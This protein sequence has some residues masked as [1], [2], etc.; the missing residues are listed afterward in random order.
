METLRALAP[1][2][3]AALGAV[4]GSCIAT[5]LFM[6]LSGVP[7]VAAVVRAGT[8]GSKPLLPFLLM[9]V[10][11]AVGWAFSRLTG[12]DLSVKFRSLSLAMVAVYLPIMVAYAPDRRAAFN[13]LL[14]T[15]V[16]LAAYY[17]GVV[18][19]VPPKGWPDVLGATTT[20]TAVAFAASP[21]A[22]IGRVLKTRDASAIPFGMVSRGGWGG[23]R[24]A[25]VDTAA[26]SCYFTGA[27]LQQLRPLACPRNWPCRSHHPARRRC[28]CSRC[29][30]RRG[31]A[32]ARCWAM[33]GW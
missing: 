10:D 7:D 22:G 21:L 32:T 23:G 20:M 19:L 5:T 33:R 12:D 4:R 18:S 26:D 1:S 27:R 24:R 15:V 8:T 31:P 29:A 28:R 11:N 25:A 3:E 30:P 6:A 16:A 9:L 17:A 13:G 14:S 2:R